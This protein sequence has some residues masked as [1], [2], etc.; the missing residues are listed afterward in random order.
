MLKNY[1]KIAMRTIWKHKGYSFINIAGLAIGITFCLLIFLYVTDE[2]NYDRTHANADRIFRLTEEFKQGDRQLRSAYIT[3]IPSL[4]E[5]FP[6]VRASVRLFTYSWKEKTLVS[7]GREFFYEEQFFLADPSL[8]RIF[9]FSF[10]AG[11]PETALADK[12]SIVISEAM[13]RK[14]FKGEDPLGKTI[15]VKNY[16]PVDFTITAVIRDMPVQSHFHCDFIAPLAAGEDLFWKSFLERNSFYTYVLLDKTSSPAALEAKF[17]DFLRRQMGEKAAG[18]Q[19]KL[20][21]LAEIHLNSHLSGEIEANGDIKYIY[22]F[23]FLA[24]VILLVACVNFINLA[25]A[26]SII[27][28]REVGL[29]KVIGARRGLLLK[30]FLGESVLMAI[31]ALPV[32][33]LLA[34]L[35]LPAFNSILNK[36]LSLE[37]TSAATILLGSAAITLF[38]GLVSGCYPAF[39]LSSYQPALVLKGKSHSGARAA[40]IRKILVVV[41]YSVSVVLVIGT[42]VVW[43]QMRYIQRRDMGFSRDQVVIVPMKDYPAQQKY[44]LIKNAWL[45]NPGI[46]DVTASEY[47]PSKIQGRHNAW[48]EGSPGN[49]EVEVF[50]N[51]VDFNYLDTYGIGL[52][53]GRG[54][55][56]ELGDE[57]KAYIINESAAKAFG[58][59]SPLG[60]KMNLSNRGLA[61]PAFETGEVIGVVKD[62]HFASLHSKIEPLVLVV[63]RMR[64]YN[65]AVKLRPETIR[66]TL[67]IMAAEWKR[68][69]PERPFDFT[70]FDDNVQSMYQADQRTG[71]VFGYSTVLS[72]LLSCLGFF[73]LASIS[74]AQRTREVGIRKVLGASLPDLVGLLSAEFMRLVMVANIL[75]L[76]VAYLVVR[77]WLAGFAY[78]IKLGP[79]FFLG[80]VGLSFAVAFVTVSLQAV[81]AALA[82]PVE[83]LRYE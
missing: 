19:L 44:D 79:E 82:D 20:Q 62:F 9:S 8:F 42:L 49:E 66:N 51:D 21:P 24:V 4:G 35:L 64:L 58:W 48:Y 14:Y 31:L 25:T 56:Q 33:F 69:V 12:N 39:I 16:N 59:D 7:N 60:K 57:R 17:P 5:E 54:F 68:I 41:Q 53:S 36:N 23:S 1:L 22:L 10:L 52:A 26:R 73:G 75:G 65:I 63:A 78:H 46:R 72:L 15:S 28:A 3:G 74:T 67:D 81:K 11:T 50:W 27:R 40:L 70:F 38:A 76:P 77:K 71:R 6:E 29:R 43:S 34:E 13:A 61:R 83:S 18:R 37:G 47:L 45:Q 30:Q 2:L 32:A 55:S 80:A